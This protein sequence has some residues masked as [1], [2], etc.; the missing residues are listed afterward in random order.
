LP[1]PA[2]PQKAFWRPPDSAT[3]GSMREPWATFELV[4]GLTV[5][6]VL[7]D[8]ELEVRDGEPAHLGQGFGAGELAA[9]DDNGDG[10]LTVTRLNLDSRAFVERGC[11][12][13]G[14]KHEWHWLKR[15]PLYRMAL[16]RI[17]GYSHAGFY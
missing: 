6:S 11:A 8:V 16:R 17:S 12:R 13:F 14:P 2:V 3:G 5:D 15:K 4:A 9:A 7:L 10:T 1:N